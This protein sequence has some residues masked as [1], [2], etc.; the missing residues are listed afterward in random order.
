M[1][2]GKKS[3]LFIMIYSFSN[4]LFQ[5]S[6]V[7]FVFLL[8]K[9]YSIL[10]RSRTFQKRIRSGLIFSCGFPV[11]F[12]WLS[13]QFPCGFPMIFLWI[14]NVFPMDFLWFPTDFLW[15]PTDF[16]WLSSGFPLDLGVYPISIPFAGQCGPPASPPQR[17]QRRKRRRRFR[18]RS[19]W[20]RSWRR[21]SGSRWAGTVE[22]EERSAKCG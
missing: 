20:R 12:L 14:S 9:S 6:L 10:L 15:F 16:L 22:P 4:L 8:V 18:R 3:P 17:R 7:M 19:R 13:Y 2:V 1:F 5:D 11:D 21:S